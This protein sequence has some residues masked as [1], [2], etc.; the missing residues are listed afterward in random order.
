[1]F[2]CMGNRP[3]PLDGCSIQR[4]LDVVGDRWMLLILRDLFRGV[5]R[6]SQLEEDLGIAKNLLASRLTKLVAADIA[7][8]VPYQDRPVRHEYFLT[9]KGRDLSP[10]LVALMGWGDR[11][12]NDGTPPTL[13]VHSECGTPLKQITQCPSCNDSLDPA[14][15]RSRPGPG[16]SVGS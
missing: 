7:S 16:A 13:L 2:A 9:Q 14:E 6:F 10:S 5:R 11:W 3:Q 8:K 1:M 12:Y 15:I 4:T